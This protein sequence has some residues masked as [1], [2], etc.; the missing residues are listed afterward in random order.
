MIKPSGYIQ[1][2]Y[3]D[4]DIKFTP[5]NSDIVI[6]ENDE[7]V[8]GAINNLF[9]TNQGERLFNPE[10]GFNFKRFIG[11]PVTDL[12]AIE[13]KENLYNNILRY[14]PRISAM[15]ID[16]FPDVDNKRYLVFI[17]VTPLYSETKTEITFTLDINR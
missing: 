9:R 14:E 8:I 7:A 10:F 15:N 17:D 6:N 5:V 12:N 13:L 4:I 1:K 16:V 2:I 11:R 3:S